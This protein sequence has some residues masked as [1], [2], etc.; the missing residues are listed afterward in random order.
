M[1]H[2]I[3]SIIEMSQVVKDTSEQQQLKVR[4]VSKSNGYI[5]R[6]E[7]LTKTAANLK[8]ILKESENVRINYHTL[9]DK[10]LTFNLNGS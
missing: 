2:L 9:V 3:N 5:I 7:N 6:I 1:P 8:L 10:T 4:Y